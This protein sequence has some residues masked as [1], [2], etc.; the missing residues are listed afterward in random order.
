MLT[1]KKFCLLH[2]VDTTEV[3]S[4]TRGGSLVA[5]PEGLGWGMRGI[6]EMETVRVEIPFFLKKE[7]LFWEVCLWR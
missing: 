1:P 4:D 3:N 7:I 6:E 2:K 5:G